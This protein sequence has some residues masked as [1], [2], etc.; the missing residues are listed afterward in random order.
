MSYALVIVFISCLSW[1]LI[2][3]LRPYTQP[4]LK[5]FITNI[6]IAFTSALVTKILTLPLV[7]M[8]S[9]TT[10]EKGWGISQLLS[11]HSNLKF[12]LTIALL[13][14]SL[15]Y[16]HRLNHKIGFLW[17]FHNV[18]HIDMDLDVTTTLRFHFGELLI[19]ALYRSA[20]IVI[21][22]VSPGEVLIFEACVT[23]FAMFHHSNIKLPISFERQLNRWFVTPRMHRIHHSIIQSEADSN[24]GTI[25]SFWDC[26]HRSLK[27]YVVPSDVQIGVPS[28]QASHDQKFSS[29]LMHPFRDPREWA[30][31]DGT[32]PSRPPHQGANRLLP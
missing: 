23:C 4:R 2:Q 26:F 1:E 13:D 10:L 16:W 12:I 5:R 3:P 8:V 19:S 27:L 14:Y 17:R 29:C 6:S 9:Q 11:S 22:G 20:Q 28:Y 21:I 30:F 25:F 32:T 31:Q 24:Y 7:L 18:H 15:Y